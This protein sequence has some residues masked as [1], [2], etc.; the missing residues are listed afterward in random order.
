MT[1]T[2]LPVWPNIVWFD[3]LPSP[4]SRNKRKTMWPHQSRSPVSIND[5]G[6]AFKSVSKRSCSRLSAPVI[7]RTWQG[8]T[9]NQHESWMNQSQ[10]GRTIT[11]PNDEIA[12]AYPCTMYRQGPAAPTTFSSC[13][14]A[15]STCLKAAWSCW[16]S[17]DISAR[18][19]ENCR[20]VSVGLYLS[21]MMFQM[22]YCLPWF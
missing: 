17:S 13:A 4:N 14:K 10:D 2:S 16:S 11:T 1:L 18:P 3:E 7:G 15:S 12:N 20:L 22:L 9:K 19:M 6:S 8:T 21:N 5:S